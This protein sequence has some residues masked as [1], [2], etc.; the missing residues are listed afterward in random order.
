MDAVKE[1]E[2]K[3]KV[4]KLLEDTQSETLPI[5]LKKI[6]KY[7][8]IILKPKPSDIKGASAMLLTGTSIVIIYATDIGNEGFQN[9]SIA[10]ELGHYF[11][12]GH[13]ISNNNKHVSVINFSS[14]NQYEQEA[15]FF[16]SSLLM[17]DFLIQDDIDKKDLSWKLID[18]IANKCKTSLEATSRR[19]IYLSK[20]PCALLVEQNNQRWY[21]IKSS[22][23]SE[24]LDK[25]GF[26]DYLDYNSYDDLPNNMEKCELEDWGIENIDPD[27]YQCYYSSIHYQ[28][29]KIEKITTLLFLEDKETIF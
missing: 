22:A 18:D 24:Y 26:P 8:N 4:K 3:N 5:D 28:D 19:I 9:F 29:N 27:K 2:I 23:W 16:A 25:A 6:T 20:E 10:H 15:N 17:P 13:P 12:D 7:Y 1:I 21:P 11:L 14:S